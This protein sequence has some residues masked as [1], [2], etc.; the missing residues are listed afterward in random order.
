ITDSQKRYKTRNWGLDSRTGPFVVSFQVKRLK[1]K[2]IND[3]SFEY[4][5]SQSCFFVVFLL[6][7]SLYHFIIVKYEGEIRLEWIV[8]ILVLVMVVLSLVRV[9]VVCSIIIAGIMAGLMAGL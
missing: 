8:I 9:N 4:Y 1:N 5:I 7:L 6:T 2:T 3:N